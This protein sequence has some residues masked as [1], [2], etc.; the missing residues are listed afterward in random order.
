MSL[1]LRKYGCSRKSLFLLGV[2]VGSFFWCYPAWSETPKTDSVAKLSLS[3][4]THTAKIGDLLWM[5]LIYEIPEDAK[6]P[7]EDGVGGLET[8]T[9]MEQKTEPN[10][11]GIRF[12]VDQ[13]ESFDLGPFSLTYTDHTNNQHQITSD[14]IFI[15][16]I[17][18]LGEKPEEA[19][20]KPIQDI[21]STQ[22]RWLPY[23]LWTMVP[24]ILL[25]GVF[26]F[27]WWRKK[28]RIRDITATM[29]EPPHV[30]A[31]KEIHDLLA[32]GLFEK[33]KVKAF[34]F[35]FSETIRR[36]MASIRRFPAA[37]MTTEEIARWVKTDPADQKILPLLKQADLVKFA[38]SIPSP[39]RKAQD[40]LM[41]RSYIQQTRPI[42]NDSQNDAVDPEVKS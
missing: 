29:E 42:L 28:H 34:Y 41:A 7:A 9:V 8:L 18:N 20:L 16:I 6:L 14:P 11:I 5:T 4:E 31:E 23:L 13:L 19:S 26:G 30:K 40:I 17:S 12:L 15:T 22:S 1:F 38:D 36:Y 2:V 10:K 39:D 37:E 35:L 32:S 24:I 27:N 3:M 25:G 33:G 21:I